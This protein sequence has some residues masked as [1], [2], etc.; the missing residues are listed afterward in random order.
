MIWFFFLCFC[1]SVVVVSNSL[2]PHGLQHT[3]LPCHS[4][5]PRVCSDSCPLS[6]WRHPS[7]SSVASFSSC[8][9]S[10]PASGSFSM[11]QLFT[12]GGQSL[13]ASL[14][15]QVVRNLS[16][17]KDTL[18]MNSIPGLGKSPGE[19]N[20]ILAWRISWTEEP[21]GL[22]SL[23]SQ[24]AGHNWTTITNWLNVE[25]ENVFQACSFKDGL[26]EMIDKYEL[27]H[28][29]LSCTHV[30]FILTKFKFPV[31]F[32]AIIYLWWVHGLSWMSFWMMIKQDLVKGP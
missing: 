6:Q 1:C 27:Y 8:P 12:S 31:A 17:M 30:S 7:I 10:F 9:Q 5:S 24:R 23:W 32:I 18:D 13:G 20:G 28:K 25:R 14:M 4:P 26:I 22:Q 16:A 21:G 11:S 3:R 19:G 2:W 15:A 29:C